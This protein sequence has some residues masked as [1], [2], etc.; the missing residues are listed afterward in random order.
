MPPQLPEQM[1]AGTR[2]MPAYKTS[3]ALDYES[4]RA[5]EIEAILGNI[6]RAGRRCAVAIPVLETLYALAK[7]VEGKTVQK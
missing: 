1:I 4:G 6:V 5:I 7:M 2:A 3:M